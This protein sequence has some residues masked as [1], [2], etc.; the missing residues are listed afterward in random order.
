MLSEDLLNKIAELFD[1]EQKEALEFTQGNRV[2]TIQK[3]V[4]Y[5][6]G[7]YLP[8]TTNEEEFL[9]A[10]ALNIHRNMVTI[11]KLADM[12]KYCELLS[13]KESYQD[14]TFIFIDREKKGKSRGVGNT[15]RV[16]EVLA[17]DKSRGGNCQR[18]E[19]YDGVE[20]Y[21]ELKDKK[22]LV[23]NMEIGFR[24]INH[25]GDI[26]EM[27]TD[28][29]GKVVVTAGSGLSDLQDIDKKIKDKEKEIEE[30]PT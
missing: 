27:K 2:M 30:M 24:S 4:R 3:Q 22:E 13:S 9:D 1:P 6:Y 26:A 25:T 29:L 28:P 5:Y 8:Y 23:T 7:N 15:Q 19:E 12:K 14:A 18:S 17:S 11:C 10:F 16:F 21:Y 20:E